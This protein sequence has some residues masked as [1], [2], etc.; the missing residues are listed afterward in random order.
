MPLVNWPFQSAKPSGS[1]PLSLGPDPTIHSPG[2]DPNSEQKP[3]PDIIILRGCSVTTKAQRDCEKRISYLRIHYPNTRLIITGCLPNATPLPTFLLQG[4]RSSHPQPTIGSDPSPTLG[5]DPKILVGSDPRITLGSDPRGNMGTDP[6]TII[7]MATSR[8]YLKIQDGCSGKCT[9]CIV[10]HFR[11]AP[12]SIPFNDIM[13]RAHAFI[14]AGYR[15]LVLTGCNLA[16]YRH[17]GH[18]LPDLLETLA[19]SLNP[20]PKGLTP[21]QDPNSIHKDLT[22]YQASNSSPKGLTPYQDLAPYQGTTKD[23]TPYQ[24][25]TP[26][27]WRIRV[28]S[29]EPGFFDDDILDVFERNDNICRFIHLSLQSGSDKVLAAMNRPYRIAAVEKFAEEAFR[30]LGPRLTL[31]ADVI[32]GF[33]GETDENFEE[34]RSF[35]ERCN[36]TNVHVFPYSERPGTYAA[37]MSRSVPIETRRERAKIIADEAYARKLQFAESLV[38]Q[39]VQVRVERG[40]DHGWSGEYLPV[41]LNSPRPRRSLA[42]VRVSSVDQGTLVESAL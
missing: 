4:A 2:S 25:L 36:F 40:G 11:G 34:T 5:S 42:K 8:A 13:T 15:E 24:G 6:K 31:G 39:E 7:P 23:P 38:G 32:T 18:N 16:L 28:G 22:P 26:W 10:P 9:F 35:L 3:L 1:D 30:R 41:R 17:D 27:Q 37:T 29:L 12:K 19:K 33:P 21:Y 14:A 20:F